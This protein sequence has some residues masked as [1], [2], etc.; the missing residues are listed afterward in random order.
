MF[1]PL[2]DRVLIRPDPVPDQTASGLHVVD[3]WPAETTGE[4]VATAPRI[5][6]SC[7]GCGAA[8]DRS[9][10][11]RAGQTVIFAPTA[12]QELRVDDTRY[13]LLTEAD[14]LAVFDPAER[15]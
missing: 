15:G 7:P 12:G 14:L 3:H 4:V 5:H 1:R 2:G 11:V 13:M 6:Q 8:L 9:P 10:T